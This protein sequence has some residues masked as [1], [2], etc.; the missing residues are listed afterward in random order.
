MKQ[1]LKLSGEVE[2]TQEEAALAMLEYLKKEKRLVDAMDGFLSARYGY[3]T[4]RVAHNTDDNGNI[5]II[6]EVSHST[7]QNVKKIFSHSKGKKSNEKRQPTG[8]KRQ[9][10]GFFRELTDF[11]SEERKKKRKEVTFDEAFET[12]KFVFPSLTERRFMIYASDK[13]QQQSKG[14]RF[15][16]KKRIFPL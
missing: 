7:D 6:C 11:L 3:S 16:G 9:N 15:D 8:F 4:K 10:V 5:T 1:N 14:F 2:L 12:M 13:R